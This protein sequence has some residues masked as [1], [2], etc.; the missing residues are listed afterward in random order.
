MPLVS[1]FRSL[2][3]CQVLE[4][5]SRGRFDGDRPALLDGEKAPRVLDQTNIRAPQT[6]AGP[7]SVGV[8]NWR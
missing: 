3:Q 7:S 1:I 6:R 8:V 5:G 2:S 4:Y